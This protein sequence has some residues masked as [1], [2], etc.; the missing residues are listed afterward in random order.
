M[1]MRLPSYQNPANRPPALIYV[2]I[3]VDGAVLFF[4]VAK[5][6]LVIKITN[7][8]RPKHFLLFLANHLC[9]YTSRRVMFSWAFACQFMFF[10]LTKFLLLLS[11]ESLIFIRKVQITLV[12]ILDLYFSWAPFW[13]GNKLF[14]TTQNTWQ[15][16]FILLFQYHIYMWWHPEFKGGNAAIVL[17]Q[18]PHQWSQSEQPRTDTGTLWACPWF[19]IILLMLSDDV[20]MVIEPAKNLEKLNHTS[21]NRQQSVSRQANDSWNRQSVSW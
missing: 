18:D 4:I 7:S 21:P 1:A 8:M 2:T 17:L 9:N 10:T 11:C 19:I 20:Q 3:Q 14:S 5:N 6:W 15:R 12:H 13:F 16:A